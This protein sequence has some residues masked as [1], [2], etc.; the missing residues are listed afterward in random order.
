MKPSTHCQHSNA[1][2]DKS[3]FNEG[4]KTYVFL[5]M[6]RTEWKVHTLLKLIKGK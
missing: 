1:F 4:T 2:H 3:N 5:T 6:L